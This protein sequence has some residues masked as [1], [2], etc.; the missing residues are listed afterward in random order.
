[1][2]S[3]QF[4]AIKFRPSLTRGE[5][6][7]IGL[8]MYVVEDQEVLVRCV[9]DTKRFQDFFGEHWVQPSL[10]EMYQE[11]LTPPPTPCSEEQLQ[12]W[13]DGVNV[14]PN[15]CLSL[16]W[17][18]A[19]GGY[20]PDPHAKFEK[21]YKKYVEVE[22]DPSP[23]AEKLAELKAWYANHPEMPDEM[24]TILQLEAKL[25][26]RPSWHPD[27]DFQIACLEAIRNCRI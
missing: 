2:K 11:V 17:Y 1:M 5:M 18:R 9:Q 10:W 14:D 23:R 26:P 3:Y 16:V 8:F 21:L 6:V 12:V 13:F 19:G 15:G 22:I 24:L 7:N 25:H 4:L 20:D 27:D